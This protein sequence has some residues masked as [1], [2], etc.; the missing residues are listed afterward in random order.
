[1]AC[2]PEFL[3]SAP[4]SPK[5]KRPPFQVAFL[6]SVLSGRC[7]AGLSTAHSPRTTRIRMLKMA[8][9]LGRRE[10]AD[11][12]VPLRYVAGR[13]ATENDAGCHFQHSCYVP[14][15]QDARYFFCSFVSV[16]MVTPIPASFSR[17]I[18]LSI[19]AGTGYTFFSSI[20]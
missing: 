2:T 20:L 1:M 7:G 5:Q 8:S 15:S 10:L 12:S 9:Q 14:I 3:V 19:T 11:R 4:S 17:A 13:R 16:S 6:F 18:S